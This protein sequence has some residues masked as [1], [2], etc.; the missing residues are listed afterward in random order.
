M[1]LPPFSLGKGFFRFLGFCASMFLGFQLSN[2]QNEGE[3][4]EQEVVLYAPPPFSFG[5]GMTFFRFLGFCASMLR[6][7]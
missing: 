6:G 1:S 3:D 4:E 2:F 5:K 7:F